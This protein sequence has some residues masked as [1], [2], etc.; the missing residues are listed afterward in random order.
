LK[1]GEKTT[2]KQQSIWKEE[3]KE[4]RMRES[5]FKPNDIF[6]DVWSRSTG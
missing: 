4:K 1:R 2:G 6:A 3:E 5:S